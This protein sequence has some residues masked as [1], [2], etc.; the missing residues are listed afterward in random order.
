M[1][2]FEYK[3][4]LAT[5]DN[6]G[7]LCAFTDDIRDITDTN[8]F[9]ASDLFFVLDT[10]REVVA[11]G[12]ISDCNIFWRYA[13]PLSQEEIEEYYVNKQENTRSLLF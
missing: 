3:R 13:T 5:N 2:N 4:K 6:I 7:K 10:L 12:Y 8:R 1:V 11:G 9:N